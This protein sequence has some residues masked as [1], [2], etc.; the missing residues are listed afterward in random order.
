MASTWL[1][2][3]IAAATA[4]GPLAFI[5]GI[6]FPAAVFIV[7]A[8]PLFADARR[9]ENRILPAILT[10]LIAADA[11]WWA[12]TVWFAPLLRTH[13]L[14]AAADLFALLRLLTGGRALRTAAGGHPERQGSAR[15]DYR[16][17]RYELSL[18]ALAGGA[19]ILVSTAALIRLLAP[20]APAA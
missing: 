1:A 15:Q 16:Q 11:T 2:V 7:T 12:G 6:A 14:L 8:P 20:M 3:R 10:G 19:A 4:T 17:R 13:P 9:P 5:A 18:A